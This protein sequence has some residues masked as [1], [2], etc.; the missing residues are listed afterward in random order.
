MAAMQKQ[1]VVSLD[2]L[3]YVTVLCKNCGGSVTMDMTKESDFQRRFGFTPVKCSICDVA[4]D[5]SVKYLDQLQEA[6]TALLGIADIITFRG[7]IESAE[8]NI[9]GVRASSGKD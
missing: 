6:Y 4:R 7:E 8:P 5:T 2:D 3:R 9:S 1:V